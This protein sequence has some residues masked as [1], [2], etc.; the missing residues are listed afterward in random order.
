MDLKNELDQRIQPWNLLRHPFYQA[1]ESGTLPLEALKTYAREYGAFIGQL[2]SG[3]SLLLDEGTAQEERE[4]A[5][6]WDQFAL[7]LETE[8]REPELPAVDA[9]VNT[10]NKLFSRL[11]TALG[12]LYAFEVQQP[13]TAKSKLDGLRKYYS[14]PGLTE[15]YFQ[16]HTSNQHEAAKLLSQIAMLHPGDREA[17]L[18][19]CSEMSEALWSAL[20]GIYERHCM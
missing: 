12:A 3:W 14:L 20:T 7:G 4:H 17:A 6:L 16:V 15:A 18:S 1:W 11:E 8:V 19:A 5:A 2:P 13:E 9:L 10:A